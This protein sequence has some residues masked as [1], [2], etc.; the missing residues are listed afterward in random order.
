MNLQNLTTYSSE[1]LTALVE[2]VWR[3]AWALYSPHLEDASPSDREWRRTNLTQW[4]DTVTITAR[5]GSPI[6]DTPRYLQVTEDCDKQG[7]PIKRRRHVS[8]HYIQR[9]TLQLPR[10]NADTVQIVNA[11]ERSFCER[12]LI[13]HAQYIPAEPLLVT[14][15]PRPWA[16]AY[17]GGGILPGGHDP[18][19]DRVAILDTQID[20]VRRTHKYALRRI[21]YV[22]DTLEKLRERAV[23]VAARLTNLQV[24]RAALLN[25]KADE[26]I[27]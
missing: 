1:G 2:E 25:Q 20:R 18:L 27:S 7:R 16:D 14:R 8:W 22:E 6:Y 23:Q 26:C 19:P 24:Q 4:W 21:G 13:D 10:R 3:R 5:Y 15:D 12:I 17:A 9:F 11:L